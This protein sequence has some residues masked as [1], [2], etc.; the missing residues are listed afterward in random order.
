MHLCA[1]LLRI[2]EVT[3]LQSFVLAVKA[4]GHSKPNNGKIS[5]VTYPEFFL[6]YI[7]P[8]VRSTLYKEKKRKLWSSFF[9]NFGLSGFAENDIYAFYFQKWPKDYPSYDNATKMFDINSSCHQRINYETFFSSYGQRDVK[10]C[11]GFHGN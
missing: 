2:S 7:S 11:S 5:S 3:K 9:Q 1:S 4:R 8:Y 6:Y 10:C